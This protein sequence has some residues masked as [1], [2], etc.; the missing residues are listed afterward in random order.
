[1]NFFQRQDEARKQTSRL[2]AFYV[3]AVVLIT[4]GVYFAVAFTFIGYKVQQG[5]TFAAN[6][7]ALWN[8]ELFL[9]VGLGTLAIVLIGSLYKVAQL[10][11][12]GAAV[13][14]MM[15]GRRVD[16]GS[17]DP[18]ERQLLNVV[19]EMSIAS[20]V[21]MPD[22][23]ILDGESG[24]NAFAAGFSTDN[25]VVAITRGGLEQF[26][27]DELQ[28]VM[29]HEFSHILNG[30]MR[31]NIRLIGILHGILVISLIG[32]FIMRSTLGAGRRSSKSD[33]KGSALPIA[34]MGLVIMVVGYIGVFFGKLIKSA[35]S[36]QREYLADAS[37]VQF[38]RHPDGIGNA[39]KR[40]GGFSN[41]SR[42]G[43]SHAEEASHL[44][45]A[46]GLRS[47][48]A[49]FF[50]THPPLEE[51]IRRIEPGFSAAVGGAPAP[52]ATAAEAAP[53]A[54]GLAGATAAG[55][56]TA[57]AAT[58]ANA[59][60]MEAVGAPGPEHVAYAESLLSSLPD[61]LRDSAHEPFGA[62]AI[63]Y[64]LLLDAKEDVRN[65]QLQSLAEHA[66]AQVYEITCA[67][68]SEVDALPV[69]ARIPLLDIALPALRRLAEGQYAQF[70]DNVD[71]LVRADEQ[72]DL[73]EYALQTALMRHLEAHFHPSP[74]APARV[75]HLLPLMPR[76][77]E[78]LSCLAGWGANT[79]EEAQKAFNSGCRE[80]LT[81]QPV[82]LVSPEACSLE[83][84]DS[85]L[86]ALEPAVPAVKQRVLSACVACIGEDGQVTVEEFELIRA[87]ADA[88][89][90][91]LPPLPAAA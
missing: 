21:P 5:G 62:R 46:N 3:L 35:V 91:P 12:G 50:A 55:A 48:W 53:G 24:I 64:A 80:L 22:V 68:S 17:A 6:V 57:P 81:D 13:A 23:Y 69:H 9:W 58:V 45:F 42:I 52:S 2:I 1:M 39:L 29:A 78:L 41:G 86:R 40:I 60:V 15:G 31:L 36:R 47:R 33:K 37:A 26:T 25:A 14:E 89:H 49:G 59:A 87:I 83:M 71:R 88:L 32:Y 7:Q 90:C 79:L 66:D 20:G 70:R 65:V 61:S 67:R 63:V 11:G 30:D 8:P 18:A 28:G 44:F 73:F 43:N 27:R 4:L 85:A 51:R 74:S 77:V 10:S 38:T 34:L 19:E 82:D 16:P 56:G 54:A 72:I 76:V 84:V 75:K